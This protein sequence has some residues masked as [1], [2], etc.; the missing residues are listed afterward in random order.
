MKKII[1]FGLACLFAVSV[2][3][4]FAGAITDAEYQALVDQLAQLTALY[5]GLLAQTSVPTTTMTGLCLS[6][7]LS[8][9]M[10]SSE[11][12]ALQQGLNQDPAT[13]VAV[14]G[15]GA[16]G[17]ETSYFGA[18]TKAAVIKFQDKYASE[19]LTSWGL[20]KGTGYAGSTTRAKFNSLYCTPVTPTTTT[21][22][23]ETTTTTVAGATEGN[24][25]ITQ[26]PLP[27]SSTVILYGGNVQKE[28]S[29]YKIKATNS[30]VRVKRVVL[31]FGLTNNFP[32]RDISAISIW[33]GGT[34][35]KEVAATS[36]NFTETTYATTYTMQLDGLDVLVAKDTEKILSI[37]ATAVQFLNMLVP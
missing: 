1:A 10:S 11:V 30:D 27:G 20:T 4:P 17:Y 24:L 32:W 15:A 29:A 7:D 25:A 8:L 31:Q 37:K 16:P 26:N 28:V 12:Q 36:S 2:A 21:L 9:G 34:L 33:D 14:S 19:V 13:Q 22:P 3:T 23:G 5:N 18:L 35:L 6:S